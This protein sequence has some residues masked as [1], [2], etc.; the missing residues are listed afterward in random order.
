[1]ERCFGDKVPTWI[2]ERGRV[3]SGLQCPRARSAL[4]IDPMLLTPAARASATIA[5]AIPG[6]A[7]NAGR[8]GMALIR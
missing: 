8:G 6:E 3:L 1:M 5:I 4:F 2:G 7:G